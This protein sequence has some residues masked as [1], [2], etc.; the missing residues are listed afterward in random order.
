[1]ADKTPKAERTVS[2]D[3]AHVYDL[4]NRVSRSVIAVIDTMTQRGGFRGEELTTIGQLRD[5]AVQ[6]VQVCETN[7]AEQAAK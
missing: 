5:Q 7:R 3:H 4:S 6:L 2:N 1:M